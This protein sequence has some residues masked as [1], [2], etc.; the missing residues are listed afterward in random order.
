MYQLAIEKFP[1]SIHNKLTLLGQNDLCL[2]ND[3]EYVEYQKKYTKEKQKSISRIYKHCYSAFP[4]NV[5]KTKSILFHSQ[6]LKRISIPKNLFLSTI[7]WEIGSRIKQNIPTSLL[8]RPIDLIKAF[9]GHLA[10]S[11][12]IIFD[13]TG[14]RII[15]GSDDRLIKVWSSK[16][17]LLIK[18]LKGH[19]GDISNLCVDYKNELL[20]SCANDFSIR[21]WSLKTLEPIHVFLYAHS[22][23]I[24]EMFFSPNPHETVLISLSLDKKICIWNLDYNEI[25]GLNFSTYDFM[26]ESNITSASISPGGTKL[27]TGHVNGSVHIWSVSPFEHIQ[28]FKDHISN[29]NCLSWSHKGGKL[30][31]G[32]FDGSFIIRSFNQYNG[33]ENH[34]KIKTS[35]GSKVPGISTALWSL[36]DE[37]IIL[38]TSA[39]HDQPRLRVWN[40]K[41]GI[42]VFDCFEHQKEIFAVDIHPLDPNV[43]ATAGYDGKVIYWNIRTGKPLYIFENEESTF[44][45]CKF[46]PNGMLFASIDNNG[47]IYI[48]GY[49]ASVN[50]SATP[51]QQFFVNDYDQIN[52]DANGYVTDS[53]TN[54]PAHM[55]ERQLLC[56]AFKNPYLKQ[57]LLPPIVDKDM[58]TKEDI[59]FQSRLRNLKRLEEIE[60]ICKYDGSNGR[61]KIEK[62]EEQE[63]IIEIVATDEDKQNNNEQNVNNMMTIDDLDTSSVEESS[64]ANELNQNND[65][66]EF[67][68]QEEELEFQNKPL[69]N[70]TKKTKTRPKRGGRNKTQSPIE[71]ENSNDE[72]DVFDV[73][74]SYNKNNKR[75]KRKSRQLNIQDISKPKKKKVDNIPIYPF[76]MSLSSH[77]TLYVPQIGDIV[78][79]FRKGHENYIKN[80][81]DYFH[82]N[83]PDIIPEVAECR[84]E[85]IVYVS[86]PFIHCIIDMTTTIDS[87]D[88]DNRQSQIQFT[89]HFH[90]CAYKS[91]EYLVLKSRFEQ[92]MKVK[93]FVEKKVASLI[94]IPDKNGTE[95]MGYWYHGTVLDYPIEKIRPE[96]CWESIKV[97]WDETEVYEEYSMNP[98]E[99]EEIDENNEVKQINIETIDPNKAELVY[100]IISE[101]A[102]RSIHAHPFKYPVSI[103]Q[104]PDYILYVPEPIDISLICERL[105][106]NYY[107]S[108]DQLIKEIKL[109]HHNALLYYEIGSEITNSAKIIVEKFLSIVK[110]VFIESNNTTYIIRK[111][112]KI[113]NG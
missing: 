113:K 101:E 80:H 100:E 53:T 17:G 25:E 5:S 31:S 83:I 59:E 7:Q 26:T 97:V 66:D 63:D 33:W 112:P 44:Y 73:L 105:K 85:N 30:L 6:H 15:T 76:W 106:N 24:S 23:P 16:T 92:S 77:S 4:N 10:P 47:V 110:K 18:S 93:W 45:D 56:D 34:I 40:A 19:T 35:M 54:I 13:R 48:F 102:E 36:D 14:N 69:L 67:I 82:D 21:I 46:S 74:S 64:E 60:S 89:V 75:K 87:L 28:S 22:E 58:F 91:P 88:D 84:V 98:W 109:I 50:Y 51:Y 96:N 52:V 62:K 9:Q 32:S 99:L 78:I 3:R 72:D 71:D 70:E 61:M 103:E 108:V 11:Y 42:K 12:C 37:H 95:G 38:T 43:F 29:V 90:P 49:K 27:A 41:S 39:R 55:I 8:Y 68:L 81:I 65:D 79:F 86:I 111:L 1:S 20:A 94:Y 57:P 104:Y 2:I 107:R